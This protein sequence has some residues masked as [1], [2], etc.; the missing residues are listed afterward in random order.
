MPIEEKPV[1]HV[2]LDYKCDKCG[3]G[4]YRST[5]LVL[6][7]S[8]PLYPLACNNSDC[9]ETRSFR[10][11]FPTTVTVLEGEQVDLKAYQD[12]WTV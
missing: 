2:M 1:R 11:T 6:T 3:K 4:H 5:G 10:T 9:G 7:C 8:P 12:R